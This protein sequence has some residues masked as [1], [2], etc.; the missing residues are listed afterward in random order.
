MALLLGFCRRLIRPGHSA[1]GDG[2]AIPRV[3]LRDGDR[4]PH[5]RGVVKFAAE[6]IEN[7]IRRVTLL[8]VRERFG[9][10]QRG[11]FSTFDTV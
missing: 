11:A 10:R 9:P 5:E 2:D 4:E 8:D 1:E 7:V 3:D 6:F